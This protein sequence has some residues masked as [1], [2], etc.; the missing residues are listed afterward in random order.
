MSSW[1]EETARIRN[2]NMVRKD[3]MWAVSKGTLYLT[4]TPAFTNWN[5]EFQERERE[6]ERDRWKAGQREGLP[7]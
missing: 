5:R 1:A 4:D 6:A 2:L 3:I 7:Q